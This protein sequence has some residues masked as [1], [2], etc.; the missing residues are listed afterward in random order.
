[1]CGLLR[2]RLRL[3]AVEAR[4]RTQL[5]G[6]A[7]EPVGC[8]LRLEHAVLVHEL[9][10]LPEHLVVGRCPHAQ[11]TLQQNGH[12][13]AH[14][15]V[16]LRL[17][18]HRHRRWRTD[19]HLRLLL[20]W[21][22]LL[23]L[24]LL[25][26][27]AVGRRLLLLLG[28]RQGPQVLQ[29]LLQLLAHRRVRRPHLGHRLEDIG[30]LVRLRDVVDQALAHERQRKLDPHHVAACVHVRREVHVHV[31]RP[32]QLGAQQEDEDDAV[33]LAARLVVGVESR[34]VAQPRHDVRRE[35]LRPA[36]RVAHRFQDAHRDLEAERVWQ[37]VGDGLDEALEEVLREGHGRLVAHRRLRPLRDHDQVAR[38]REDLVLAA[39]HRHGDV[40]PLRLHLHR[41]EGQVQARV[42]VLVRL[43]GL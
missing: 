24:L 15:C 25:I 16:Q 9:Q 37:R 3:R 32:Q 40:A 23:L 28:R 4:L 2:L 34:V 5:R 13:L 19:R 12:V 10:V 30:E 31:L 6:D 43:Q 18:G 38:E 8:L 41:L 39:E 42:H 14:G 21:L 26:R 11:P 36:A 29:P 35:L 20:L 27:L 7:E 1:M 22:L 17:R 33:H